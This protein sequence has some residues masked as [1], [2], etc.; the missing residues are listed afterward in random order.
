[1]HTVIETNS[2]SCARYVLGVDAPEAVVVFRAV[3]FHARLRA[4]AVI[5]AAQAP[6]AL[7][8]LGPGEMLRIFVGGLV[9]CGRGALLLG[10]L[11]CIDARDRI[12][13]DIGLQLARGEAVGQVGLLLLVQ[14]VGVGV[15]VCF[16]LLVIVLV[17]HGACLLV[18]LQ[19]LV[20][21]GDVWACARISHGFG[22]WRHRGRRGTL[23][24][25]GLAWRYRI[26]CVLR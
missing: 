13:D 17:L 7:L 9:F 8:R 2:T 4:L 3:L 15:H 12:I 25:H 1:M 10:D 24:G 6:A 14:V 18:L 16:T 11:Q 5:V 26:G 19:L 21:G 22:G 23:G 20:G